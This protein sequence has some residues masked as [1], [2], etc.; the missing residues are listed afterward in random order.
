MIFHM[1]RIRLGEETFWGA[2]KELYAEKRFQKASWADFK[3]AFERHGK[4]SLQ[5][6]FDQWLHRKG[7]PELT[8]ER[9]GL[10]SS[11]RGWRI[12]GH[13]VQQ[14][15]FYDLNLNL[16][17]QGRTEEVTQEIRVTG[18]QTPFEIYS[19]QA[20]EVLKVD[21]NF[22]I[23]R[24]LHLSELPPSINALKA[25][26]PVI[27]VTTESARGRQA[28]F[29]ELL[30]LC[31]GLRDFR[32]VA[33]DRLEEKDIH[34]NNIVFLGPPRNSSYLPKLP[35]GVTIGRS[36]FAVSD[37]EYDGH[38]DVF[39]GVFQHP[40]AQEKVIS[41]LVSPSVDAASDIARKITHYGKYSYLVFSQGRT[42]EKG[43]WPVTDSPL[44]Y[45]WSEPG[46]Q[47]RKEG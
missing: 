3:R 44:I 23:F 46:R 7:A 39:F 5:E 4:V 25:A 45:R 11:D 43:I 12:A 9:V 10:E 22:D 2:L 17:T 21:P 14:E 28:D 33:E 13:I 36:S 40:A 16:L 19:Q 34:Q 15:P 41:I 47:E 29:A 30:A 26:S 8:L 38:S 42:V 24:R 18:R 32:V 31:L 6:Y 1:L 20:P 27:L 35:S 37:R